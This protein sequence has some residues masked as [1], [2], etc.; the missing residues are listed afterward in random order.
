MS[1]SNNMERAIDIYQN[2]RDGQSAVFNAVKQGTLLVDNWLM[3]ES[4][5]IISPIFIMNV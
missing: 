2:S 5:E 4:C 3:C 1:I